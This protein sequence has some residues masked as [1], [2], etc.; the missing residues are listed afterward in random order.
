[1]S[2]V[3][4]SAESLVR[5]AKALYGKH[6]GD[7]SKEV[8]EGERAHWVEV[9]E[10]AAGY[11]RTAMLEPGMKSRLL[12]SGDVPATLVEVVSIRFETLAL[13][14]LPDGS[15]R[16]ASVDS[17]IDWGADFGWTYVGEDG[18]EWT[19]HIDTFNEER[20]PHPLTGEPWRGR[21]QPDVLKAASLLAEAEADDE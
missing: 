13:I 19:S 3:M 10:I 16:E 11:F 8:P 15:T 12:S 2:K 21:I 18:K 1:M 14:R 9:A 17:L 7:F 4:I 20:G 5:L 6:V